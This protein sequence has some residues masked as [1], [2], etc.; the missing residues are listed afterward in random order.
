VSPEVMDVLTAHDW[1]GNVRQLAHVIER[2][3][4]MSQGKPIEVDSLPDEIRQV[5]QVDGMRPHRSRTTTED[6]FHRLVNGRESFWETV[7]PLY[8]RREITRDHVRD[9]ID[10]GLREARGNYK[11]LLEMFNMDR[12]EYKR[13]LDFLRNHDCRLS[14]RHYRNVERQPIVGSLT[15]TSP[16]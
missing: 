3:V 7:Y 4:I 9:V 15:H 12:R 5:R 13:F 6:L 14:F 16:S 1:P 8:M 2:L 11:I 10:Q